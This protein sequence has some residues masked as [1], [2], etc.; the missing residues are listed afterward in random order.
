VGSAQLHLMF[1]IPESKKLTLRLTLL[2]LALPLYSSSKLTC[3]TPV[4]FVRLLESGPV[5]FTILYW[6]PVSGVHRFRSPFELD[7]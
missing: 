4:I 5:V 6:K 2:S 7:P 3:Y 1:R